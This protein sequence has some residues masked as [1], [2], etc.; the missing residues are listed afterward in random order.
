MGSK[1]VED[2][3][4][5]RKEGNQYW[6]RRQTVQ[7]GALPILPLKVQSCGLQHRQGNRIPFRGTISANFIRHPR[8]RQPRDSCW[9]TPPLPKQSE[10]KEKTLGLALSL[11]PS[12]HP[13]PPVLR[14]SKIKDNHSVKHFNEGLHGHR[15]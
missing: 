13:I 10:G 11:C 7:G 4:M 5:K 12:L 6:G 14:N 9:H 8:C 2:P 3:E 15:M 1:E